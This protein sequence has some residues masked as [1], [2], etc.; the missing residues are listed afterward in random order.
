VLAEAEKCPEKEE[1]NA[2]TKN[3]DQRSF[4]YFTATFFSC[5]LRS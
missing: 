4:P 5:G 1:F 2:P 3:I